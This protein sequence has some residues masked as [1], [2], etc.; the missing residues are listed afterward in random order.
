VHLKAV[1]EHNRDEEIEHASMTLEW[2][3]R[4]LS[5]FDE[6]LR[7]YL[8]KSGDITA[9]EAAAKGENGESKDTADGVGRSAGKFRF[10]VGDMK[11][12]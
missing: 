9:A 4:N 10:T 7:V 3:R 5:K 12:N 8:F 2:I 11:G 1:L 6:S